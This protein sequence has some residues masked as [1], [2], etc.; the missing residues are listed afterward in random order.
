MQNASFRASR[1]SNSCSNSCSKVHPDK[2]G[3]IREYSKLQK[4]L[5]QPC[6]CAARSWLKARLADSVEQTDWPARWP[7]FS[8][9]ASGMIC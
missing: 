2:L 8:L 7:H 5:K 4:V 3:Q 9:L 6:Y 1:L